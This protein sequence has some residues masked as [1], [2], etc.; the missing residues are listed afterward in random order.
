M[1]TLVHQTYFEFRDADFRKVELY[2]F[3]GR[4]SAHNNTASLFS[5]A[6]ANNGVL[7]APVLFAASIYMVLGRI[8]CAVHG[9]RF[10]IIRI[11]WLTRA[12]VAGDILSFTVQGSSV[13]LNVTGHNTGAKAVIIIGLLIQIVSFSLF[14]VTAVVFHRRITAPTSESLNPNIPW[15]EILHMLHGMSALIMVRSIFRLIENIMGTSGYILQHEWAMYVFDSILMLTVI[16]IFYIRYP[17]CIYNRKMVNED[18]EQSVRLN[19]AAV[20]LG[21]LPGGYYPMQ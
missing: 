13:G 21:S 8:I 17:S 20:S 12:F 1:F 19:L 16:V 7:L 14:G 15:K 3:G 4:C 11:N 18:N 2:G 5:Y 6:L 9:E 10:S